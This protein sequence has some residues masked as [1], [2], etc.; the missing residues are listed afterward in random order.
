M[1]QLMAATL[2]HFLQAKEIYCS[3]KQRGPTTFDQWAIL[4]KRGNLRVNSNKLMQETTD[5]QDLN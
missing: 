2:L 1:Q 3:L 5:S 4:Q